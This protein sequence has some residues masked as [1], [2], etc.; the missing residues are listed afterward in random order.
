MKLC[1]CIRN[2]NCGSLGDPGRRRFLAGAAAGLPAAAVFPT[3]PAKAALDPDRR[4]FMEEATRLATESVQNGWGGPF[5]CVIVKDG[6]I[7]GRG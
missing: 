6:E 1:N 2:C 4:K 3:A 5:G 7:I